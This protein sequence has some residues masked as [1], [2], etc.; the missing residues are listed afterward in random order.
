MDYTYP[1][2][3]NCLSFKMDED[4]TVEVTDHLNEEIYNMTLAEVRYAKMLDGETHPYDIET[5]LSQEEIDDLL[6]DLEDY[7]LLKESNKMKLSAGS[8]LRTL[9]EI[10][11]TRKLR[12]IG[13]V[14]N[15]ALLLLWLPVLVVGLMKS[16]KYLFDLG[17]I[18][19]NMLQFF[20]GNI[21]GIF[22]AIFLHE[23]GHVFAGL[24]CGAKVFE[25]GLM[26]SYFIMPGAYVLMDTKRVKNRMKRVQISA[27]GV[28]MNFLLAGLFLIL[29]ATVRPLAAFFII[30]ALNNLI[31]AVLNLTFIKGLD[32]AA[33]MSELLGNEETVLNSTD[34]V[35]DERLRR[36]IKRHGKSGRA[37]VAVCYILSF[38][39]LTMP[40]IL[41][42]NVLEVILCF[43]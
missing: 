10:K 41:I 30:I 16:W 5:E 34:V 2:L 22:I 31:I 6:F 35:F 3:L 28:E 11:T 7:G 24:S 39:Q 8:T 12:I 36:R 27:A 38:L 40:I 26:N 19:D 33:V 17:V 37:T 13:A 25:M 23:L 42:I 14:F 43:V 29:T 21:V 9:W 20:L 15:K 4:G 32:G 1:K 18:Y